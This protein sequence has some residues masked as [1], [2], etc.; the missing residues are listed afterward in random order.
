MSCVCSAQLVGNPE[1][2]FSHDMAHISA[3]E[4]TGQDGQTGSFLDS[5]WQATTPHQQTIECSLRR[6][7]GACNLAVSDKCVVLKITYAEKTKAQI[8]C[9]V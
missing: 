8:S 4:S 9:A 6:N 3:K 7:Q 2:N 1:D 5:N